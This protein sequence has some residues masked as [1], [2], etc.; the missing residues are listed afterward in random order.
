MEDGI[1]PTTSE[2]QRA[3]HEALLWFPKQENATIQEV[4]PCYT[5]T[6]DGAV[7][8]QAEYRCWSL[9]LLQIFALIRSAV[10]LHRTLGATLDE[11]LADVL[12]SDHH[13]VIVV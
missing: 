3:L 4:Q 8:V 5:T 11:I 12:N 6:E 1:H 7:G 9:L 2:E 13:C 10:P